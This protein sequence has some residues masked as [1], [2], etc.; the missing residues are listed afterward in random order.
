MSEHER[1]KLRFHSDDYQFAKIDINLCGE[2]LPHFAGLV[3]NESF[4]GCCLILLK[5][6]SLE[7]GQQC[8]VQFNA[9]PM[10]L[11]EVMWV[12]EIDTDVVK[13]GLR[14]EG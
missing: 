14:Y 5:N 11:A 10:L 1:H 8:R 12:K 13:I 7:K 9:L 2:F 3:L 6:Q 4:D